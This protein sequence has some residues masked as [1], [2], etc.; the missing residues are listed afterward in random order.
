MEILFSF[1]LSFMFSVN[2][3]AANSNANLQR[4]F[5]ENKNE[6]E[7]ILKKSEYSSLNIKSMSP[8][9]K[10]N[11]SASKILPQTQLPSSAGTIDILI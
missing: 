2:T 11:S 9:S 1:F 10:S 3:M 7:E 4:I 5:D 6:L 8:E